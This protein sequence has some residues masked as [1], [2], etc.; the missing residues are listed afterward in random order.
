[1]KQVNLIYLILIVLINSCTTRKDD[2]WISLFKG[3]DLN[4]WKQLGGKAK[5]EALN[6][7]I[8]GTTV[9]GTNNSFL[10]TEKNYSDFI[11]KLELLVEEGMNS[12]IQFR[13]ESTPEYKNGRVHGYQCEVDP[14]SRAWS[15]GIYDEARRG[16]IYPGILNPEGGKA[17][18][19]GQWNKYRIECIGNSIRTWLNGV[20]VTWL[21]DD[22]TPEGFICLQVHSVKNVNRVGKQIHW[23]NIRIKTEN[24]KPSPVDD[25]FIVNLIP[26]NLS[27]E[28]KGQGWELLFD[29]KTTNGWRGANLDHFPDKGWE[30][31]D[32][33]LSVLESDGAESQ[34]GGDIITREQYSAFELQLDFK[35]TEGANSGVKYFVDLD[36]NSDASAIG[37][38]FQ[39]QGDAHSDDPKENH[40]LASLY[41]LI[42]AQLQRVKKARVL[43]NV[44]EWNHARIVVNR[45]NHVEHW[46]NGIKVL[47]YTRGD[48]NFKALVAKSKYARWDGF[49]Q[50]KKGHI[51]LQDHGN[52]VSFRD[53]KIKILD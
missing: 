36:Y 15:G 3:K 18:K 19:H 2:N 27:S 43:R 20:P 33:I 53:I 51:L 6:G 21:V 48:E 52:R 22:M 45:N 23:R 29:G 9:A 30:I 14:S 40:V 4:G 17:F 13:S 32:G 39:L 46:L 11:L 10:T 38:E 31:K 26:N 5:Y 42:P 8:V 44:G 24:L 34:N 37:L 1:M 28:E 41:D 7:E 50:A 16:W 25:I 12:G 49:G 47:E 35:L